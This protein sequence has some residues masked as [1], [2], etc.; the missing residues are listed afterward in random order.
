MSLHC[1]KADAGDLEGAAACSRHSPLSESGS[2]L[3]SSHLDTDVIASLVY[4]LPLNPVL[5]QYLLT[6]M[7]C[8]F[9]ILVF[10]LCS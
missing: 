9:E 1:W 6:S 7:F 5:F 8:L 3:C 10:I 2:V 4:H